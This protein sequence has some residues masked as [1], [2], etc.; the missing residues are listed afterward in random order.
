MTRI[1]FLHAHISLVRKKGV[2]ESYHVITECDH[3][4]SRKPDASSRYAAVL[5]VRQPPLLPMPMR[6]ENTGEWSIS[7][8]RRPIQ[9][10]PQIKSWKR[11]KIYLFDCVTIAC[12]RV[13]YVRL[14]R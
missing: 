3:S 14:Q 4:L 11:L 6:I 8:T 12:N 1:K 9:I 2:V 10:A 7:P 13:K 5:A